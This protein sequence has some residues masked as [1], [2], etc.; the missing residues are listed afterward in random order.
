MDIGS[1]PLLKAFSLV[2]NGSSLVY[3]TITTT[4][5]SES[6]VV[7]TLYFG[8]GT[9]TYNDVVY[10]YVTNLQGDVVAILDTTGTAVVE[11]TYDAW[12]NILTTTG[13]M[14]N[15]LGMA[16]PLTYRGYVYDAESSLYYLQSRYY[17]ANVGRFIN[18]DIL[19]STGHG[20]LG[21]NMFAYCLN[22]PVY[23]ADA[24]GCSSVIPL[25]NIRDYFFMHRAVQYDIAEEYGFGI[26]VFISGSKGIG[27]LDLYD[28]TTN[29][30][31]EVKH[32]GAHEGDLFDKQMEK[33]DASHVS[34]WRFEE[35]SI[36]G[37]V[38]RGNQILMGETQYSFW[39]IYYTSE[40]PGIITYVWVVNKERYAAYLALVACVATC[41]IA[42]HYT[43]CGR[44]Q[45]PEEVAFG[46]AT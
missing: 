14:A 2:Y 25:P 19:V 1:R 31:Y 9:V 33:Y 26:E 5:Y 44:I 42:T 39:D 23:R 3:L 17:N 45:Q 27:R 6:P 34:G 18:A 30:Y 10:Y 43:S 15:T 29:E 4:E 24:T 28:G 7:E 46:L 36:S 20:L 13:S 21:N 22:S 41:A 40:G 38:T 16:N 32:Y 35:Y 37:N 8:N 12:G 11:Y